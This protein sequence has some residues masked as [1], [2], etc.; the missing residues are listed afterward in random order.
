MAR[1]TK[2]VPPAKSRN[3]SLLLGEDIRKDFTS[4]FVKFQRKSDCE[5]EELI[6]NSNY[7]SNS[8]VVVIQDMDLHGCDVVACAVEHFEMEFRM[9]AIEFIG[10]RSRGTACLSISA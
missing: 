6:S 4:E 9:K 8:K 1:T 5:E 10:N 7:E 3:V 2:L